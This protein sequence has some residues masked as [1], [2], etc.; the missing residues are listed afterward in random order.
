MELAGRQPWTWRPNHFWLSDPST[1][2]LG[3]AGKAGAAS[4]QMAGYE[5]EKRG[6]GCRA[7]PPRLAGERSKISWGEDPHTVPGLC[8]STG[9]YIASLEF[10][11]I[12]P[13]CLYIANC[14]CAFL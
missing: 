8:I 11:K 14:R 4:Q 3:S 7:G 9:P 13:R 6:R 12:N 1:P 5:E 2:A 10:W